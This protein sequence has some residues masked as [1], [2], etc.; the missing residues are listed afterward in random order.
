MVDIDQEVVE[1]SRKYL[2]LFP[3]G[4]FKDK[5]LNLLFA[6]GKTLSKKTK[7]FDAIVVDSTDPVGPGKA[8]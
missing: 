8:L 3:G 5:R 2:P 1:L 4:S 7:T 6:D